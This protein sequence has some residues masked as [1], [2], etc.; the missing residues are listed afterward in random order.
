MM[1]ITGDAVATEVQ[2]QFEK[3]PLKRKPQTRGDGVHEWVPLS[4][5]VAQGMDLVTS[6]AFWPVN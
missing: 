1:D 5:I 2:S 4:G 6:S 3:L